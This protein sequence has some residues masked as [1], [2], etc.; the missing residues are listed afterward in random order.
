[1]HDTHLS[2]FG[3]ASL[4]RQHASTVGIPAQLAAPRRPSSW[5][6]HTAAIYERE[7]GLPP[8]RQAAQTPDERPAPTAC[9]P[10]PSHVLINIVISCFQITNVCQ[11]LGLHLR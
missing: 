8:V 9:A 4:T 1:M 5:A 7:K 6:P 2:P 11:M 10:F 3:C